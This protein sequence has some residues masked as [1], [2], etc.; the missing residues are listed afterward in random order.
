MIGF[1]SGSVLIV[2]VLVVVALLILMLAL[3]MLRRI[4]AHMR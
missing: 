3:S 2:A 4:S 1:S